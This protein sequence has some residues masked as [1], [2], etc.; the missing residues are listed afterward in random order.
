MPKYNDVLVVN[1]FGGPCAGKS[2]AAPK[3]YVE[4]K[5]RQL[6]CELAR[7]V[8]K[9]LIYEERHVA[10]TNELYIF[11]QQA[12]IL[13]RLKDRVDIIVTDCPLLM[14]LVYPNGGVDLTQV[15]LDTNKQYHNLNIFVNRSEHYHKEARFQDY[16]EAIQKDHEILALLEKFDV[17]Y[18]E[19]NITDVDYATKVADLVEAE[20][21]RI[22]S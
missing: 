3:V 4:L 19:I 20:L 21:R 16:E 8:I 12:H 1:F 11:A 14:K 5:E 10:I 6:N 9:D 18:T 15:V 22:K 13:H 7:E 17:P 2:T